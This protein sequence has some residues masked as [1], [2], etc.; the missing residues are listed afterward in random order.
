MV[1]VGYSDFEEGK[2]QYAAFE[3]GVAR[4]QCDPDAVSVNTIAYPVAAAARTEAE[5]RMAPV[6]GL[7]RDI[8]GLAL[9]SGGAEL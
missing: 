7:Y 2:R 6:A 1:F 5:D 4:L 9:L 3:D 8:D